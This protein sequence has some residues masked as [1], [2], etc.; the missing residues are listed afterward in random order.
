MEKFCDEQTRDWIQNRQGNVPALAAR[1]GY[2]SFLW[3]A[4]VLLMVATHPRGSTQVPQQWSSQLHGG[5]KLRSIG[6]R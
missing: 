2:A 6:A 5:A 4:G 3:I 1:N